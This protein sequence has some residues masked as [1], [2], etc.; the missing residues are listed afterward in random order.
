MLANLDSK[1]P[2]NPTWPGGRFGVDRGLDDPALHLVC[3]LEERFTMLAGIGGGEFRGVGADVDVDV[4]LSAAVVILHACNVDVDL[5]CNV[6]ASLLAAAGHDAALG[7]G[8]I[9]RPVP[10]V[11][12][13][14]KD[15]RG[16]G[17]HG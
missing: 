17:W 13:P 1:R 11:V 15:L 3:G 12:P 2:P 14:V 4:P 10:V 8:E 6:D 7:A 5:L 9:P 16:A